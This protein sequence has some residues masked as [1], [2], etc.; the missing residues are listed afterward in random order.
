MTRVKVSCLISATPRCGSTLLCE[1]LR[2]TKLGGRPEEYFSI[3]L[4]AAYRR[5][6]KVPADFSSY[7]EKA[8]EAGTTPNGVF[9]AK[10]M[11]SDAEPLFSQLRVH[12]GAQASDRPTMHELLGRL[13]LNLHYVLIERKDK[14]A[15]AVSFAIALQTGA[16]VKRPGLTRDPNPKLEYN[17]HQIDYLLNEINAHTIAWNRYFRSTG[18][19]IKRVLYDDLKENIEDTARDVLDHLGVGMPVDAEFAR[20]FLQKQ[21]DQVNEEW[22]ARYRAGK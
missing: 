15:Q 4:L 13:F 11:W 1:A 9:A 20:V 22:I 3:H 14:V 19:K 6:W 16:W 7:V 10:L 12:Y 17:R 8:I 2:R 18:V 21:S 5:L